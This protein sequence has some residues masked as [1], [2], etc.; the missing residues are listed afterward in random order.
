MV[1]L[2]KENPV[3]NVFGISRYAPNIAR[4]CMHTIVQT[5]LYSES[6]L[7]SHAHAHARHA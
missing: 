1:A 5:R 6:C 7:D 4:E 2:H 3:A